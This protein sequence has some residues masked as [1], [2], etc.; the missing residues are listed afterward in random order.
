MNKWR[1]VNRFHKNWNIQF[2]YSIPV[3]RRHSNCIIATK[4]LV[5]DSREMED[6]KWCYSMKEANYKKQKQIDE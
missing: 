5:P 3:P 2:I 6:K 1:I 4:V